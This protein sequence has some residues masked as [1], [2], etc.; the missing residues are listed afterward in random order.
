MHRIVVQCEN[1]LVRAA[2]LNGEQLVEYYAERQVNKP[3]VGN[4][5]KGRVVNV[6]PGMQ[7]AFVQIG[8]EKNAFLYIDDVLPAHLEKVPKV[9]PSISEVLKEGQELLVQVAKEPIGTKGARV[10]THISIPGRWLVYMPNADY[11]AVSRKIESDAERERLKRIGEELRDGEEGMIVRTVAEEVSKQA[12]KN[13]L[14]TL[15]EIW[16][17][18]MNKS[19]DAPVPTELYRELDM[20]D[21][22]VRDIMTDQVSELVMNDPVRADKVRSIVQGIHAGWADRVV[23]SPG[24]SLMKRYGIDDKLEKALRSKIWLD[25]GGYIIIDRTEALTVIDVNTGKFTGSVD[26]EE[27]VF[28]TNLEAAEDIARLLRLRDIGGIIIIDF[29]DMSEEAHRDAVLS[30]LSE[31]LKKDRT[32]AQVVGWTRLGLVEITRKKVREDLDEVFFETCSACGGSGRLHSKLHPAYG[33][34]WRKS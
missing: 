26:L 15:R 2:L 4:V 7:A 10:T 22:L 1:G 12:L 8:L 28:R 30:C 24:T 25:S 18:I 21:R 3:L 14:N 31:A 17:Q 32:K 34:G 27:T 5:Y 29:I 23:V 11:I 19:I 16:F 13:D 33:N 20:V 6:L 9:K